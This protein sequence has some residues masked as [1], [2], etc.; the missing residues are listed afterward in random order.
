[1]VSIET[2]YSINS[3]DSIV[4]T[5]RIVSEMANQIVISS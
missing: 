2:L 4:S 1:M 5:V 3:F